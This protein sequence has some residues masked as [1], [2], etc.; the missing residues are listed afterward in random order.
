MSRSQQRHPRGIYFIRPVGMDGP[1]K[2][3]TTIRIAFRLAD[4]NAMSPVKLELLALIP[5]DHLLE[6]RFHAYFADTHSHSE[7]FKWSPKMDETVAAILAG[8]FGFDSLPAGVRVD[9]R[10]KHERLTPPK[11][12][13]PRNHWGTMRSEPRRGAAA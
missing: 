13:R 2:I 1:V 12:P 6:R 7:W 8:D 10:P 4:L 3:G 9:Y 5:G 11:S